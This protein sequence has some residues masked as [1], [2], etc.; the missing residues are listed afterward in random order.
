MKKINKIGLKE[1]KQIFARSVI[2]GHTDEYIESIGSI[3][4][5]ESSTLTWLNPSRKDRDDLLENTKSSFIIVDMGNYHLK[6]NRLLI[7]SDNPKLT[8]INFINSILV[9]S[10]KYEIHETAIISPKAII[11]KRVNIG[12]YSVLGECVI[13]D[14]S[15][16]SASCHIGDN[17]TIGDNVRLKPGV[18]IGT[19]GYG[20]VLN[21]QGKQI[22]FPHIGG[23]CIGNNVDIGANT[24]IDKGTLDD[25]IIMDGV[26]IDNLVHVA[27][28]VRIGAN[29]MIIANA[30]IAGST[31]IGDNV[32]VA[33]SASLR[34]SI[35]IG[36]DCFVGIGAV[37]TKSI[38]GG[39]AWAGNPARKLK[40]NS[41][42]GAI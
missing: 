5:A 38:E 28:N 19:A 1:I 12:A 41:G 26:K 16:I 17:V 10:L 14:D 31:I 35:N 32:T 37:V 34:E 36:N 8:Y 42:N 9:S 27:H 15:F 25:T 29:S 7:K 6:P 30:M 33:P 22:H 4:Q 13:G 39:E 20:Y 24:C 18:V 40:V 11:G 21:E 23:V 2:E 3:F